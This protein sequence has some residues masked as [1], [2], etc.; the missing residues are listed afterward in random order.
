[1]PG[2]MSSYVELGP[3]LVTLDGHFGFGPVTAV[4][5]C[6]RATELAR[7]TGVGVVLVRHSN[8]LGMLAYYL[9]RIARAGDVA[10]VLST[11]EAVARPAGGVERLLG[12]NPI[13]VAFPADPPFVLDMS[14]TATSVGALLHA[15]RHG[16]PIPPGWA[17]DELGQS[18]EDPDAAL[19]GA[20]N[21]FGGVKGYGLS[22]AVAL[23]SGALTG[24]ATGP[25]VH[26]V[27]DTRLVST[28]GEVFLVLDPRRLP[29]GDEVSARATAYLAE[30]RRS[31]PVDPAHP[32][33][34]PG[35]RGR[36]RASLA[37]GQDRLRLTA[38][39]W[40]E[41]NR[42]ADGRFD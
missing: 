34:I 22:L 30:V 21:P 9:E 41:L 32:V 11:T 3:S 13:G 39:L 27:L 26:G 6:H 12:S 23:M 18:T 24:T 29:W 20:L 19:R 36:V 10:I 42:R 16:E 35:D 14:T 31:S 4:D 5:A 25:R 28:K 1:G 2:A 37:R 17:V 7:R 8:H 40:A 38:Q 15:Q 33:L